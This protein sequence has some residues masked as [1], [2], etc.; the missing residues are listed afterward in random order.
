MPS[1]GVD[2]L[3]V[4]SFTISPQPSLSPDA[5]LT[6]QQ[7]LAAVTAQLPALSCQPAQASHAADTSSCQHMFST[8]SVADSSRSDTSP[9]S[10]HAGQTGGN[11]WQHASA[12]DVCARANGSAPKQAAAAVREKDV[13]GV[14]FLSNS[15]GSVEFVLAQDSSVYL[16]RGTLHSC[17]PAASAEHLATPPHQLEPPPGSKTV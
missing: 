4:T 6:Q 3:C 17:G 15:M 5:P 10:T 1:S 11:S 7:Q 8:P 2:E 14:V 12:A 13:R 9:A 16:K